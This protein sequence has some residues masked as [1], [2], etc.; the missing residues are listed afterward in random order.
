[1]TTTIL[2]SWHTPVTVARLG[3]ATGTGEVPRLLD[4]SGVD[5]AWLQS[6]LDLPGQ[7]VGTVT[8]DDDPGPAAVAGV[9]R[10][11]P[12][13]YDV[14]RAGGTPQADLASRDSACWW[15][16]GPWSGPRP[17]DAATSTLLA[18]LLERWLHDRTDAP[19]QDAWLLAPGRTEL[20]TV[21]GWGDE[22]VYLPRLA[23]M[24]PVLYR[25]RVPA[26]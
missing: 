7:R 16:A 23:R 20:D 11:L 24:I 9:F 14:L 22:P 5:A 19:A 25:D 8:F 26:A 4:A 17:R 10:V 6:W 3:T 1:M 21:L 15:I 18:E 13:A 12:A 2:R